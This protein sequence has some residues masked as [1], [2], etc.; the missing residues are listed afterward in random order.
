MADAACPDQFI[1]FARTLPEISRPIV[2]RHFRAELAV[3]Q[4]ADD[5]PVTIADREA[6]A[7]LRAAIEEAFP[8]HG[9]LGE[10]HGETRM[11]A[12][13]VW[14]LDPIDGTRAFISG[15]PMFGTLVALCH[16]GVPILGLV[17][18]AGLDETWLGANGHP[19]LCDGG[20]VHARACGALDQSTLV[21]TTP[22]MFEEGEDRAAFARVRG[23]IRYF[24]FGTDCVGYTLVAGGWVDFACE[25]MLAPYDYLAH[26][27]VVLGA[28]GAMTGW[29][30]SALT[31]ES[32]E[33][34]A[35]A[36]G[37][38]DRHGELLKVLQG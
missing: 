33:T 11:D 21:A 12:E 8:D 24:R 29:D 37:D 25:T 10:E 2:L 36:S 13:Y 14:V 1:A 3:E 23:R 38:R 17:D 22:E 7:A 19:T 28:G 16:R 32:G 6:E 5:S 35:L 31:L 9:I 4:K 20:P 26:V 18:L 27:P 30:G 15:I 34:R